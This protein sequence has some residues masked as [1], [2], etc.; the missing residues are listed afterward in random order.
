MGAPVAQPPS[1]EATYKV[2]ET[3]GVSDLFFY[4]KVGF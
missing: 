1:V 3:E 4:R 2:R